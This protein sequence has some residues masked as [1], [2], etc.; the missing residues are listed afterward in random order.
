MTNEM[1]LL[2]GYENRKIFNSD[3]NDYQYYNLGVYS[4]LNDALE[5]LKNY[6]LDKHNYGCTECDI[7]N[8]DDDITEEQFKENKCPD[9]ECKGKLKKYCPDMYIGFKIEKYNILS[10]AIYKKKYGFHEGGED[11]YRCEYNEKLNQIEQWY[12]SKKL[13]S[14]SSNDPINL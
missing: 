5:D 3:D 14:R 11:I 9:P 13:N 10:E 12:L 8:W 7:D 1:F 2:I 4:N 6:E